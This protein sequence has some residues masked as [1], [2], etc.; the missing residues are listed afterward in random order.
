MTGENITWSE[1]VLQD[2]GFEDWEEMTTKVQLAVAINR[3]VKGRHLTQSEA[4]ELLGTTQPKMSKLQ[5]YRL[6]GF[7]VEKLFTFLTSL[8]RDVEIR[9][10]KR[11]RSRQEARVAVVA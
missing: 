6:D 9:I 7:S 4:A 1:N 3:I 5:H 8:D 10:R 11:P 2:L